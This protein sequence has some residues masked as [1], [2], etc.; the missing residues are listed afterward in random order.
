[1]TLLRILKLGLGYPL[2]ATVLLVFLPI[3]LPMAI[4][5]NY[6]NLANRL[7]GLPG[8]RAGGGSQSALVSFVYLS[9]AV[10][11]FGGI[12]SVTAVSG[13]AGD[14]QSPTSETVVTSSVAK[15][16]TESQTPVSVPT[17]E[18]VHSVATTS[19]AQVTDNNISAGRKTS[20]WVSE[21]ATSEDSVTTT[22]ITSTETRQNT[23]SSSEKNFTETFR[24][25][26]RGDN[27]TV[28]IVALENDRK[29]GSFLLIYNV[30][31]I[32]NNGT[33]WLNNF[34]AVNRAY[35]EAVYEAQN[36]TGRSPWKMTAIGINNSDNDHATGFI[37]KSSDA[38][39]YYDGDI[40]YSEYLNKSRN[41]TV[42]L[43]IN[44]SDKAY[45]NKYG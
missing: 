17:N 42:Y 40:K 11:L 38:I 1:M 2:V 14:E 18:T 29:N 15:S 31:S 23:Y 39:S 28:D 41:S 4:G 19:R 36:E 27:V 44:E 24:K 22:I 33:E 30:S 20:R 5:R 21:T 7:A 12:S 3:S 9:V 45:E 16:T 32:N 8:I 34:Y 43:A 26:I 35:V 10:L 6:R 13:E 37:I 25:K